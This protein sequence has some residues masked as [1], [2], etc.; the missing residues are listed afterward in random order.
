VHDIYKDTQIDILDVG[1]LVRN[2][3]HVV[4]F[5]LFPLIVLSFVKR[6]LT[7]WC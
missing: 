4:G 3:T 5:I 1:N 7:S 6:K 2:G